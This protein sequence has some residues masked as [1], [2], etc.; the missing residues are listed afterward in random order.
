MSYFVSIDKEEQLALVLALYV[1]DQLGSPAPKKIQVLRFVKA[2]GLITL[3]DDDDLLREN[4]EPKWMNDLSWAR[5]DIKNRGFLVMPEIGVW[6]ISEK[7]RLW[8]VETA[9][10]WLELSEK[11]PASKTDFLS[12][13]RRLNERFFL[14]M[15][16]LARG[17][18]IRK[19]PDSVAPKPFPSS[20]TA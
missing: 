16:L 11:D 13:C 12:R 18:D 8:L 15:I 7:G 6:M 3:Y 4:G 17:Q 14:H 10:R 5:E 19:V 20:S 1:L 2:R 9:K